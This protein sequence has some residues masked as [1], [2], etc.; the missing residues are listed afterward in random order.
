VEAAPEPF[1]CILI[2]PPP[3]ACTLGAGRTLAVLDAGG[4]IEV[5]ITPGRS[6]VWTRATA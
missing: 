5:A 3:L 2:F 1:A 4:G 6:S